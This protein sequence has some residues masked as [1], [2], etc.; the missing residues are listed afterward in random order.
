MKNIIYYNKLIVENAPLLSGIFTYSD[1]AAVLGTS[2]KT[3]LPRR[4]GQ[5]EKAGIIKRFTKGVYVCEG[6]NLE[7]LSQRL[8]SDSY[9]SLECVLAE[10]IVIG[11]IPEK[12]I[13]AILLG[14]G[15]NRIVTSQDFT[16]E[17][18]RI[19]PSK[20]FGFSNENGVNKADAE[21]AFLDVLYFY[22]K[23]RKT[24]FNIYSDVNHDRLDFKKIET[25]LSCYKNPKFKKF[26]MRVCHAE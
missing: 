11:P 12:K 25:Y 10:K 22:Q 17:Q 5:L 24:T 3:L 14:K 4:I 21:K 8:H 16:I 18:V 2:D 20:Y 15:R 26:V 23:G 7:Q 1:L 9:I 6:F 19:D 13:T